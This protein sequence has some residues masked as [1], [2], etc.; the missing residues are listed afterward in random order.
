MKSL[1]SLFGFFLLFSFTVHDSMAQKVSYTTPGGWSVGFGAGASYQKSDLANSRGYGLDFVLGSSLYHRENSFLSVGWNFR[2]LGGQNRA[3]DH[4]INPDFTY[5]NIHYNFFTYDLELNLTLNRLRERTGIVLTGFAGAGVTFGRTFTDLYDGR[6]NLYDFGSIDPNLDRKMVYRDLVALSDGDFETSLVKKAAFL[7]TAGIFVGYQL[8]RSLTLGIE[9]KSNFYLTE[10]NGHFGID[11]DNKVIDGSAIDRNNYVSLGLS[12]NLRGFSSTR[13]MKA[14]QIDGADTHGSV[15][16]S[17]NLNIQGSLPYPAVKITEPFAESTR[18]GSPNQIIRAT[19]ENVNGP[20]N[21]HFLQNG[22]PL[23]NFTYNTNTKS[24]IAN[25]R[26]REGENNFRIEA[27]NQASTAEDLVMITLELPPAAIVHTPSDRYGSPAGERYTPSSEI[28]GNPPVSNYGQPVPAGNYT[29]PVPVGGYIQPVPVGYVSAPVPVTNFNPSFPGRYTTPP[30][31]VGVVENRYATGTE[32]KN[33]AVRSDVQIINDPRTRISRSN[34]P[35]PINPGTGNPGNNNPGYSNPG[36]TNPG[37][38]N[39]G[40]ADPGHSSGSRNG[41]GPEGRGRESVTETIPPGTT[42][43]AAS[44]IRFNPGNSDWQFCLVTPSGTYTRDHLTNSNFSYSGTATSLYF[45]PIGGGGNA[46]V[47]GYPYAISSG[48]YYLF[49]GRLNVTVS[50]KNPGSM[51]HWSAIV[52]ADNAPV[53]GNGNNRPKSPL[54]TDSSNGAKK[55]N[56][57]SGG[58]GSGNSNGKGN[59]NKSNSI[60]SSSTSSNNRSN[61]NQDHNSNRRSD[62]RSDDASDR[63]SRR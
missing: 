62:E 44:E 7:P 54:E 19:I 29:Q 50:T 5:S 3:Y 12:W 57:N 40:Y 49:T 33:V 48:Q 15:A 13:R 37:N 25:V 31:Q 4:R 20:D 41:S 35:R 11:I 34:D 17:R 55:D 63:R 18:T 30:V 60:N 6:S 53:A 10:E 32:T 8:S 36:Y 38:N 16:V 27:V 24:F 22:F 58:K 61:S 9:Y 14:K 51:G 39:P 21:I 42:P 52:A 26:L 56:G 1:A 47:N 23:N 45:M 59:S 46:T 43:S 28:A 2:F